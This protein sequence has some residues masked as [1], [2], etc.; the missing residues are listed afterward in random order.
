MMVR[1]P[2]LRQSFDV[3]D[4]ECVSRPCFWPGE[5]KGIYVQGRGYTSYHKKPRKVCM[6][7]HLYGCPTAS[8]CV[9]CRS[10]Q[11][12]GQTKCGWCGGLD[13]EAH[14]WKEGE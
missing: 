8:V 4:K 13:L 5:D 10:V 3:L 2:K 6:Q 14:G 12:V 9:D 1:F 11:V 7:R